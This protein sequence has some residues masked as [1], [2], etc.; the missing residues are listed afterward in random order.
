MGFFKRLGLYWSYATRSLARGGQRTL[1]A[2]FC[3]AVGVL[4]IVSLQLVGNMVNN[5]LTSNVREGNGGD[6]SLRSDFS[7]FT[8][9]QLSYF[10]TLKAE[11][12]ID[13]YT[14]MVETRSQALD[15]DGD[16]HFFIVRAIDPN[17]FPLAGAPVFRDPSDGSF[18]SQL[19]GNNVVV[20]NNLLTNLSAQIGDT[21]TV[22]ATDGRMLEA[23]ISGV[24][25]GEGFFRRPEMLVN[26]TTY[27]ALKSTAGLPAAYAAVYVNV[28]GHTDEAADAAKKLL[29]DQFS[30]ATIT[31]TKDALA[32]NESQVQNIRYFLQVVGLLAL[33]IGGIGIVNTMQVL[34]RR[35]QTE[36]AML[37]TT[38]YRRIDLY[39]LFGLEAA[40]LGVIGGVVGASAGVGVSFFVKGLVEKAFFIH[41]PNAVDPLTVASGVLIGLVTA[42]IFGLMP[43]VQASQVR[44]LAVL[45]G[46][47]EGAGRTSFFLTLLLAA[48]LAGS[49]FALSFAILGNLYV[50]GG[51]IAGT[52]A[53][54]LLLSLSFSLIVFVIS[55]LPVP[56]GISIWSALVAVVLLVAA[57]ALMYFIPS[58]GVMALA[59]AALVAIV[60]FMPRMW[61]SNVKIALRNIGR[62]RARTV[63][64]LVALFVGVF[65]IG[66]IL[67]L[68]QNIKDQIDQALSSQVTYNSFL[69]VNAQNKDAVDHQLDTIGGIQGQSVNAFAQDVPVAV[70]GVP[71]GQVIKNAPRN[72]GADNVGRSGA[73]YF[74]SGVQAFDLKNGQK[75]DVT[76]ATAEL[77]D[78]AGSLLGPEDAGSNYVLMPYAA[79][80]APLNLRVGSELSL[81]SFGAKT[82]PQTFIVKGFYTSKALATFLPILG[83]DSVVAAL[84]PQGKNYIYSLKLD[85]VQADQKLQQIQK[86]VPTVQYFSLVDLKIFINTL[87]NN[88][89][90]M[91]TAVASLAMLAGLI[92]IAN[93]VALAMLERRRELGILKSVGFTSRSVLSEVLFENGVI[94]FVGSLLAIGLVAGATIGLD[95]ILFKSGLGVSL[96][97]VGGII[98]ATTLIC[99]L[100]A[101]LVAWNSTRVRPLEVLRYE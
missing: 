3:V 7:P 27:T 58:L 74:L 64:T 14:A 100:V 90:I 26:Q 1:L 13:D 25:E 34:L 4:A 36:I 95:K 42:L 99:V 21:V 60:V 80:L 79:T 11:G 52:G 28:P 10:D 23:T 8:S 20:T 86:A 15:K 30:T 101:G 63:T 19:T 96:P 65:G 73:Q 32:E 6:I 50:A 71:I 45:R 93:A 81:T 75:P 35:R 84:S 54:L 69:F 67:V 61:K 62:G 55:R 29:S 9:D 2:I 22:R 41:L 98:A 18:A 33:L 44:P 5:G 24:I 94:G 51:V 39:A 70:D 31:T 66:L 72:G 91:L 57:G 38:G 53:F 40:I 97:I 92:I 82:P 87:L 68:G 85:P 17:N 47:S 56:E 49:F 37:K 89:I 46:T 76:L 43:I 88:L 77:G 59:V 16:T 83:D 48:I 78:K 12:K